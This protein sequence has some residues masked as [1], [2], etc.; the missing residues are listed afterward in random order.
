M[1]SWGYFSS[2]CQFQVFSF[3]PSFPWAQSAKLLWEQELYIPFKY[4][5]T[6]TFFHTF[7]ADV[8]DSIFKYQYLQKVFL[9]DLSGFIAFAQAC[10]VGLNF[11]NEAEAEEFYLILEAVQKERGWNNESAWLNSSTHSKDVF[12]PFKAFMSVHISLF[13]QGFCVSETTT[14]MFEVTNDDEEESSTSEAANSGWQGC[15]I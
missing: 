8:R 13:S 12:S 2:R 14:V 3:N 1:L 15:H 5:A 11:A 9:T 4:N 6:R 10:H 7:P